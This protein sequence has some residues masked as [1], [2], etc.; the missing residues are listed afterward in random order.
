[1]ARTQHAL[2]DPV[3]S[4]CRRR[5][6]ATARGDPRSGRRHRIHRLGSEGVHARRPEPVLNHSTVV[7]HPTAV[8]NQTGGGFDDDIEIYV[9]ATL[10]AYMAWS[11]CS[12]RRPSYARLMR[13]TGALLHPRISSLWLNLD[14]NGNDDAVRQAAEWDMGAFQRTC[15]RL[16]KPMSFDAS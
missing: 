11:Y 7:H 10:A 14:R 5:R 6:T 12:S 16:S 2:R 1:M 9:F 4:Y 13:T 8:Q 15:P 3:V